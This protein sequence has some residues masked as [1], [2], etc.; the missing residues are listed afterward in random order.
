MGPK[1]VQRSQVMFEL[2]HLEN[3]HGEVLVNAGQREMKC[4][5]ILRMTEYIF[6]YTK[7]KHFKRISMFL[8]LCSTND[9]ENLQYCDNLF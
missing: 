3:G 6:W 5:P 7:K 8:Y 9:L 1:T 2:V 4:L